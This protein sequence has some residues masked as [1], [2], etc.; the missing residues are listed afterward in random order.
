MHAAPTSHLQTCRHGGV[1]S[2]LYP[3][4]ARLA[5]GVDTRKTKASGILVSEGEDVSAS[6]CHRL[7]GLAIRNHELDT[8]CKVW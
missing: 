3:P 8:A 2:N 1:D 6:F 7:A 4:S 5:K